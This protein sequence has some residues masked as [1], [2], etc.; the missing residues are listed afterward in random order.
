M[1]RGTLIERRVRHATATVVSV[2]RDV[3]HGELRYLV[4]CH[5]YAQLGWGSHTGLLVVD[6]YAQ[7]RRWAARPQDWC[8]E[9]QGGRHPLPQHP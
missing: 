3:W 4:R 7:G 6:T 9:C 8:P 1:A 5:G 2:T